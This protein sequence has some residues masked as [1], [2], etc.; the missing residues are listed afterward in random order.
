MLSTKNIVDKWDNKIYSGVVVKGIDLSGMTKEAAEETLN[1]KFRENLSDKK[2][3]FSVDNKK[4]TYI[5]G[6]SCFY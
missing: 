1:K 4:Y 2:I 5:Y 6:S 3:E